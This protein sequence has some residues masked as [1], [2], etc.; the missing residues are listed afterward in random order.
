MGQITSLFA[1]KVARQAPDDVDWARLLRSIGV[2]P[3]A[4]VDPSHMIADTDYYAFVETIARADPRGVELPLRTGA[5]MRC[6]DYGA[7][8]LAWKSAP[9]LRGSFERAERYGRVLTSV[10][11]YEVE[12]VDG[13]AYMH[14]HRAGERRLGLRLSNEN[15]IV[16]IHAISDQVATA[17]F[18]PRAIYFKHPAPPS[19][20]AHE[21][22][23][24]CQVH[25]GAD[26]DALLVSDAVLDRPNKLGDPSIAHFF[27]AHLETELAKL[28]DDVSLDQRVRIQVSQSLSAGVPSISEIGGRLGLSGRTLQRRLSDRGLSFQTLVDE[29]RRQ[30][31]ER[32]LHET[33]YSL[34][35]VSFLAGFSEQSAFT[36]A[37]KRWSGRTPRS[38]RLETQGRGG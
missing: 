27:D 29:A 4:P 24:G 26:R 37:F 13:G 18:Q 17:P 35:E 28:E 11:A 3:D 25:F 23:F 22:H 7:F 9:T 1:W 2:D 14:L 10:S 36:R 30:L 33:R 31:A 34:A 16:S 5:S 32:L 38:Y 20:A 12:K 21:R 19:I 6:D 8:G 15:T